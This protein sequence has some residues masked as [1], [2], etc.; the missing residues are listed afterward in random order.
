MSINLSYLR[1]NSEEIKNGLIKKI[2]VTEFVVL[3]VIASYCDEFNVS[4]ISQRSIADFSG[5]TLPTVN[6]AIN[7]LINK[8]IDGEFIVKREL[9]KGARR[10]SQSVYRLNL[11]KIN[12]C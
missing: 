6:K 3:C 10:S 12:V 7:R 2:G 4:K 8:K 5:L 9:L 11:K 1:I